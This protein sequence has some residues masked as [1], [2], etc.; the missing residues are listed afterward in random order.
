MLIWLVIGGGLCSL[1]FFFPTAFVEFMMGVSALGVAAVLLVFPIPPNIQIALWLVLST[2][3]V[4]A[5]RRFL[6]PRTS[7]RTLSDD[8]EAET[9]TAIAAGKTGRVLYEGN[10]WRARCADETVA[11]QPNETVYVVR[12]EGTTL[13]VM[14]RH[15]LT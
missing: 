3:A 4:I 10:S 13:Y 7:K 12:Q 8:S 1:E 14:P 15:L 11:I 6:T 5:S 2:T 9:L